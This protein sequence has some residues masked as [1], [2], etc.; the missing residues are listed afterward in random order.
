MGEALR[1]RRPPQGEQGV[2]ELPQACKY[3][4]VQGSQ[5]M[6]PTPPQ[7]HPKTHSIASPNFGALLRE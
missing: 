7:G 2:R 4:Q 3:L 6:P 5:P 1:I